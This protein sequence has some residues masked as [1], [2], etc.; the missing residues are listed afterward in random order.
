MNN[1]TSTMLWSD[2]VVIYEQR[3]SKNIHCFQED[4]KCSMEDGNNIG[5]FLPNFM[6][7]EILAFMNQT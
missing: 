3:A 6:V 7:W 2:L 1:E 5:D 4:H